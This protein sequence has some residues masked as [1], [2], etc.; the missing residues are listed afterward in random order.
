VYFGIPIIL[1][2]YLIGSISM[3]YL[4]GKFIYKIDITKKG[5]GNAG[6]ANA[7]RIMGFKV[8]LFSGLFDLFKGTLAV[9]IAAYYTR[10][11]A[12][13]DVWADP[14]WIVVGSALA[15]V[16]GHC[17]SPLLKFKG[18]KGGATTA[19]VFL[20]ISPEIFGILLFVWLLVV[21]TTRFT[22]LGNLIAIV[23]IQFVLA[24]R[25]STISEKMTDYHSGL[26]YIAMGIV[27]LVLIYYKHNDNIIR[28]SKGLERK[29][30]QSEKKARSG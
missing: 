7:A 21:S 6:G 26:P 23:V 29:F 1:L 24:L 8:G 5:S 11:G 15:V 14:N 12:Y 19:G 22:S 2:S 16:F 30:G 10:T 9:A 20:F 18:G 13:S 4:I 17:Y 25:A 27:L 28:L 3:S